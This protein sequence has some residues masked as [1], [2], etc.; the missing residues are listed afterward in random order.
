MKYIDQ[1]ENVKVRIETNPRVFVEWNNTEEGRDKKESYER[2]SA[3]NE[4]FISYTNQYNPNLKIYKGDSM[5]D[6]LEE[7][8]NKNK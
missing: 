4:A 7:I 8:Y 1:I 3:F 2:V 5:F 6:V